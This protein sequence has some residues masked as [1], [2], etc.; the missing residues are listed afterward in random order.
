MKRL[1]LVLAFLAVNFAALSCLS[2]S[3]MA[4]T[5]VFKDPFESYLP[6]ES[7]EYAKTRKGDAAEDLGPPPITI[8]GVLWGT[9]T[10]SVII[11]GDVYRVGDT[12]KSLDAKVFKINKNV[13]F[14]TYG[15][16]I[17]EMSVK[18]RGF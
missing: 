8:N 17:F 15:E 6:K 7:E 12:L 18:T 10:P 16:R 1:L 9:E 14:I 4:Q 11:D 5:T 2:L 13:V 3:L